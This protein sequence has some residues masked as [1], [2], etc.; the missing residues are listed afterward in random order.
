MNDRTETKTNEQQESFRDRLATVDAKGKRK[1]VFA[2][3]P[4]GRYYNIRTCV[5]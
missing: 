4:V 2:Q 1:W 3:K 5:R